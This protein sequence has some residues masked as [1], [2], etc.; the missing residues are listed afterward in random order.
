MKR[1]FMDCRDH[2]SDI[3]CTVSLFAATKEEL[4][5]AVIH[6]RR[7]VHGNEDT[8]QFRKAIAKRLK[9]APPLLRCHRF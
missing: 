9:E 8:P 7:K 3:N 1:Y 2:P 6:H 4:L 5:E